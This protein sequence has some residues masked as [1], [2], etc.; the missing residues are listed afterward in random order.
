[1]PNGRESGG[2][3]IVVS[4]P[5]GVGKGTIVAR[6]VAHDPTLWLS[7][8]WTTRARRP[9]EA[10]DAYR[11][12]DRPTFDAAVAKG[13][14]LEWVEFVPGHLSGT[15]R[16]DPPPGHDVVLEI[17]VEGARQVR[18]VRPDALIILVVAPSV[19]AQEA[20]MRQRGDTEEQIARRVAL[21]SREEAVGRGLADHVIVNDDLDRAVDELAGILAR[22]RAEP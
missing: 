20:R 18:A 21:G 3:V 12:V 7:R 8:S 11:F 14:F 2:R 16:P 4:G 19:A 22:R 5:G 9:G 10:P 15:P 6:L 1:M 13:E 17:D